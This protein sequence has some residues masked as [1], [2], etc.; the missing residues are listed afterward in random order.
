VVYIILR[1]SAMDI[2]TDDLREQV[3]KEHADKLDNAREQKEILEDCNN[4]IAAYE[5]NRSLSIEGICDEIEVYTAARGNYYE[6]I[7]FHF[8]MFLETFNYKKYMYLRFYNNIKSDPYY[9]GSALNAKNLAAVIKDSSLET[10][11]NNNYKSQ[12]TQEMFAELVSKRIK[13]VFVI[14]NYYRNNIKHPY[15]Y[16]SN[17]YNYLIKDMIYDY[18]YLIDKYIVLSPCDCDDIF[19]N[20]IDIYNNVATDT[21]IIEDISNNIYSIDFETFVELS[22]IIKYY[23][24]HF[25]RDGT[26]TLNTFYRD[27]M[28]SLVIPELYKVFLN[29]I[30]KSKNIYDIFERSKYLYSVDVKEE[31]NYI[32]KDLC[33]NIAGLIFICKCNYVDKLWRMIFS[34]NHYYHYYPEKKVID[35]I[36]EYIVS[37]VSGSGSD[38]A[39]KRRSDGTKKNDIGI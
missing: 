32:N 7:L 3:L 27:T 19:L 10:I 30:K 28:S 38:E 17:I 39:A 26:K 13:D 31:L 4:Y 33:P 29:N 35:K 37:S 9:G 15:I 8:Q 21:L 22:F 25:S 36:Y 11:F 2:I 20:N 1:T 5:Y 6:L 23:A 16:K 34:N 18:T 24:E 14:Y 12:R